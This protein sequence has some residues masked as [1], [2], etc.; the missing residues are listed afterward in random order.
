MKVDKVDIVRVEEVAPGQLVWLN[1]DWREVR[2][3]PSAFGSSLLHFVNSA[4][5]QFMSST[6]TIHVRSK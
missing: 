4:V 1:G 3:N 6:A 5:A 2:S